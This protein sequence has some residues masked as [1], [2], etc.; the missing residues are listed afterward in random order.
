MR[1]LDHSE[2]EIEADW[3]QVCKDLGIFLD[4]IQENFELPV[5]FKKLELPW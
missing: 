4:E 2:D 3:K 5:D 1:E